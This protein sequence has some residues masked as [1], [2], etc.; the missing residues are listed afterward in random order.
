M[1]RFAC[2]GRRFYNAHP[3]SVPGL[4][5]RNERADGG[6]GPGRR[7]RTGRSKP[8]PPS[9]RISDYRPSGRSA[10]AGYGFPAWESNAGNPGR[11]ARRSALGNPRC[12]RRG[13]ILS[14]IASVRFAAGLPP[15]RRRRDGCLGQSRR[16]ALGQL[17]R[18][19]HRRAVPRPSCGAD[20][21]GREGAVG[22]RAE[23][24]AHFERPATSI[25]STRGASR[26]PSESSG[27]LMKCARMKASDLRVTPVEAPHDGLGTAG[28]C[29]EP[30]LAQ[31]RI[32]PIER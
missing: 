24:S 15:H 29:R 14:R 5:P 26:P 32:G 13:F 2:H 19:G 1:N 21:A 18:H 11:P 7:L 23:S 20:S 9:A 22:N 10:A 6:V 8:P 3:S 28:R 25:C 16:I 4:C 31:R 27:G 12:L 17:H 30:S